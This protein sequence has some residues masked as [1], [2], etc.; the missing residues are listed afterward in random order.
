[1]NGDLEPSSAPMGRAGWERDVSWVQIS[2]L[3][4]SPSR[5]QGRSPAS[6]LPGP[7]PNLLLR[8]K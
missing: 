7:A 8:G 6:R 3:T 1:M 4:V 5:L 2:K